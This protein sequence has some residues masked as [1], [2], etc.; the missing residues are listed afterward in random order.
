MKHICKILL[1]VFVVLNYSTFSQERS[2]EDEGLVYLKS[3]LEFLASDLLEGRETG[4]RGTYLASFFITSELKKY[5][6]KP[7]GDNG[8]YFQNFNLLDRKY[9]ESSRITII[10]EK[11]DSE[12]LIIGDD[13]HI[14]S[15]QMPSFK[16]SKLKKDVVF[17][18]YG[19]VTDD[20]RY[21]DYE[22]IDVKGKIVLL[23]QGFPNV[24]IPFPDDDVKHTIAN[25]MK[26][27][28]AI[29]QGAAGILIIPTE[30]TINYWRFIK[31]GATKSSLELYSGEID[32]VQREGNSIPLARL[33][34][35][36]VIKLLE[37]EKLTYQQ[38][39]EAVEKNKIPDPFHLTNQVKF[40]YDYSI[41]IKQA[42]NV[43]GLIEG[44]D[45]S[46]KDQYVTFSAHY[47][48][49]GIIDGKIY[50]GA[51]DDGSGT[52]TILEA[53]RRISLQKKNKRPILVIFHTGEEKGL[54]GSEYL[55]NNSDFVKDI[56][57]NINMDMVG[58]E[59]TG[60][61]YCIGSDKL[62]TELYELVEEVNSETSRF[63][64]DYTY[65]DPFDPNRYYYRSDHYNYAKLDIPIVFFYDHMTVDYHKPT[66]DVE[67]INFPKLEKC[68]SLLTELALRISNLDHKL[69]VDK[70]EEK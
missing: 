42:R 66:D 47:D 36:A 56:V 70:I 5:G 52:V 43:I 65:N 19:I 69:I 33:N 24:D 31:A 18:R 21:N 3:N 45:E 54:L 26:L 48:H 44:S 7:F 37:G 11:R 32:S 20:K 17:A 6:V 40:D 67:K 50:N 4:T 46:L 53:A 39:K 28:S 62:S 61:I 12:Q 16:Y 58:R 63:K 9:D 27:N 59:E 14:S 23:L 41:E 35:G 10:Y 51:D 2:F 22:N 34:E 13:F 55:T 38:M 8:M 57:V 29:E 15:E 60:E 1:L 64:L 30:G 25:N 49:E 68:T